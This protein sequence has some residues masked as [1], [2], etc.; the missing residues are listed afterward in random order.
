MTNLEVEC[1]QLRAGIEAL[2]QAV[3][4]LA[5][6][7]MAVVGYDFF[8]NHDTHGV[9]LWGVVFIFFGCTW[10]AVKKHLLK[11]IGRDL[12]EGEF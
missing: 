12:K 2:I 8:H 9:Q 1:A 4:G 11:K 7:F 3:S 6:L 10:I 5:S